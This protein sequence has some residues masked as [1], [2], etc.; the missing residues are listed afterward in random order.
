[1]VGLALPRGLALLHINTPLVL[2]QDSFPPNNTLCTVLE[3]AFQ[4]LQYQTFVESQS[5]VFRANYV[6]DFSNAVS[7]FELAHLDSNSAGVF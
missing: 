7:S 6:K 2:D 4:S 5:I 1:M 3:I